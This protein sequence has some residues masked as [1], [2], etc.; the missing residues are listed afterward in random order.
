MVEY[1]VYL[2]GA[3]GN[4]QFSFIYTELD[5]VHNLIDLLLDGSRLISIDMYKE[6]K[7]ED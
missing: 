6:V 5:Q 2:K 1:T 7:D 3:D 4:T